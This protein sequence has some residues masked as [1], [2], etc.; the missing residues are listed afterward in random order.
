MEQVADKSNNFN[1]LQDYKYLRQRG[2]EFIQ[3][4]SGSAWTNLNHSDP[5]VTILEQV[6]YAMTELG[7]CSSFPIEDILTEGNNNIHYTNQFYTAEEVFNKTPIALSEYKAYIK[8]ISQSILAVG[9]KTFNS[10]ADFVNGTYSFYLCVKPDLEDQD[11]LALEVYFELNKVRDLC[12]IFVL[13]AIVPTTKYT[14]QGTLV[15]NTNKTGDR[16]IGEISNAISCFISQKWESYFDQQEEKNGEENLRINAYEFSHCVDSISSIKALRDVAIVLP[17]GSIADYLVIGANNFGFIDVGQSLQNGTLQIVYENKNIVF[18]DVLNFGANN[19]SPKHEND[20]TFQH[21]SFRDIADYFSI[22]ETFPALYKVG[23]HS[24]E[25]SKNS[26]ETALSR[27]FRGYLLLI[28]QIIS[29]QFAQLSHIPE[30]FSF[31]ALGT[32]NYSVLKEYFA[33]VSDNDFLQYPAPELYFTPTYFYNTLY[34]VPYVMPLLK[35]N[36]IFENDN[37]NIDP[38]LIQKRAYEEYIADPYNPYNQALLSFSAKNR[39]NIDRKNDILNHLLAR[40]GVSPDVIDML[41]KDAYFTGVENLDKILTKSNLLIHFSRLS[42][43]RSCGFNFLAA[44]S[45]VNPYQNLPDKNIQE[46]HEKWVIDSV[47]NPESIYNQLHISKQDLINFSTFEL[48]GWLMLGFKPAYEY[49]I[50]ELENK[51]NNIHDLEKIR[52]LNWFSKERKGFVL[53]EDVLL[54]SLAQYRVSL[55]YG[56]SLKPDFRIYPELSFDELV[57][58]KGF[59]QRSKGWLETIEANGWVQLGNKKFIVQPL[60]DENGPSTENARTGKLNYTVTALYGVL[61]ISEIESSAAGQ[62]IFFILPGYVP[63]LNNSAFIS[64]IETFLSEYLPIHITPKLIYLSQTEI[65]LFIPLYTEWHNLL[66]WRSDKN[67]KGP[68]SHLAGGKLYAQLLKIS[69]HV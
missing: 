20:E 61:E 21:G 40:H 14:L 30:L 28:D 24:T 5:G 42:S 63:L 44:T 12:E 47:L 60:V 6:V 18:D 54:R 1:M 17:D 49:A 58:F 3:E 8:R 11:S 35:H 22:Q 46:P 69:Q 9:V 13:P 32:A 64:K 7:Y 16:I 33:G 48:L 25:D 62:T 37:P 29:N 43:R 68:T 59:A 39:D 27:Q 15:L 65:E 10:R 31:K 36:S 67:S 19:S 50:F 56:N 51:E 66:R 23:V 55:K 34:Q 26:Y 52:Q 57:A 2:M 38:A 53:I 45:I 4:L 41:C